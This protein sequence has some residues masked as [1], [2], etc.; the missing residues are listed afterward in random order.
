MDG[1]RPNAQR[2]PWQ[3]LGPDRIGQINNQWNTAIGNHFNNFNVN[4]WN[5]L[6]PDRAGYWNGWADGVRRNWATTLPAYRPW[7]NGSWWASHPIHHGYWHY[8]YMNRPWRY[9]WTVPTWAAVTSWFPSYGWSDNGYYY[10]YGTGGNVVYQDNRVMCDGEDVGSAE[11]YSQSAADL[12]AVDPP[13]DDQAAADSEWLPLGTFGLSTSK[14]DTD[15]TRVLQLA[16]NKQGVVSGTMYNTK[17]DATYTLQGRVD[18]QSQRV[19]F[20]VV[21]RPNSVIETGLYNLTQD[22]APALIHHGN[23]KTEQ[24]LLVRM[25]APEDTSQEF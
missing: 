9:W 13:A 22:D 6:H 14:D 7:F 25:E 23:N 24:I 15:L 19:A 11:E 1:L 4:N 3:N 20:S 10:D 2:P 17:T 12:A 8:G 21:D 18:K 5:N 16:V